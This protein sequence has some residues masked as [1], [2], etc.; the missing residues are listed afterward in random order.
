[1]RR[2]LLKALAAAA[3]L[4]L[5]VFAA[6]CHY[7][8]RSLPQIDGAVRV[9]GL[10]API[11]I[12][13]DADAIPHIFAAN[14]ADALFGL[15][16]A[17]AQDRL[18]QMELQRRIGFGRLSEVLGAAALPQDRFLRTVGFGR[19]AKRA[20]ESTPAW[21]RQQI[22]A[23]VAGVNAFIA[24][25]HGAQLPPEFT[26]LNFEPAPF[27]GADVVV[28][29]KMMAWDLSANY[30]FE[31]LRHDLVNAVGAERMNQLM[32]PYAPN[33]LNILDRSGGP[34][35]PGES[36]GS[37]PSDASHGSHGFSGSS[38]SSEA[39][40]SAIRST[41]S[42]NPS[43]VPDLAGLRDVRHTSYAAAFAAALSQGD[44]LVRD[45]LTGGA[46][47]E[48]LGSNNWVVDGT[49]TASGKPL[50]ANDPHLGTRIPSTWYLAHVTG[51]DFEITGATLPGAPAVALGRNRFIAWGATNVAADVQDLYRET[52]D[53]SGR[54]ALF[55]GVEE[56]MTIVTETIAVK[57]AAPVRLDVRITRHGPLI[58]D[59]INANNAE[60]KSQPK[61]GPVEPLAFRWTALDSS[62][63]T[64]ASF[65]KVNDARNW[66]EF[67]AALRDFVTPSQNF[68][69]ADVE[70][71]IGY[72]AP[73]RIPIRASGDG[74]LPADGASG[75]AEW[76][77]WIPFDALPHLYDPPDH[78]IVTANHRPAP[79]SYPYLLGLEWPEPYRG[80][81]VVDLLRARSALT[82]DDFARVQADTVSLHAKTLLPL[83]LSRVRTA[84]T[85]DQ[86]AID[87][88]R[89]W[90]GDASGGSAA[91][92]IFAAWFH[93]LAPVIAGDD[94]G[95]LLTDRYKERY[96]YV[97]RFIIRTLTA[98][99]E[100]W[101]D[102]RTTTT[103]ETCEDAVN[104]ALRRGIADLEQRL[105]SDMTRWRWDAVHQAVFPHQGLDAVAV[106]RPLLSRSVPNGGDWSTVNVGPVDALHPYEQH[107]VPGYREIIDLSPANDS[108]FIDAVGE[109]GHFLSAHYDDFQRDWQAVR[110]RKMRMTRADADAGAI[111]RLH[112]VP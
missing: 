90:N 37:G 61:P 27:T 17:H 9:N 66:N 89:T 48:A 23:Y 54:A 59:A 81:R 46:R 53:A 86:R 109:S 93:Q 33:G 105:G 10:S 65:L 43:D 110:Y 16:Y 70:G 32:P 112:L 41:R 62:D 97:T 18:W 31:L 34:A 69:Y 13:R 103:R 8:R 64:V 74:S 39:R 83:L 19:A 35:E 55:R 20:W 30:S 50:L 101:C 11:D 47:T 104:I 38:A 51:G 100:S 102:D 6:G 52:L 60:S 45:V 49:L 28:W 72:F 111:G 56:P 3:V 75:D 4:L 79:P 78:L 84:G 14:K 106:L 22:D 68:V 77:G 15:G 87:L 29:V 80:Q 63:T 85:P 95:V 26:L 82:P 25:H 108:R 5:V 92:A 58:S 99:D 107:S 24:T 40:V 1:M 94:L 98:G 73:G 21:A 67:T 57:G 76:T 91:A 88:L 12:I 2:L 96:S 36:G 44:P 71:H 42:P 7:L